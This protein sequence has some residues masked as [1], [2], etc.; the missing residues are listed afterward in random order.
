MKYVC[1]ILLFNNDL[2]VLINDIFDLLCI[3]VGYVE[4]FDEVVVVESVL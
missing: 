3:E 2:L 4:L 1:V